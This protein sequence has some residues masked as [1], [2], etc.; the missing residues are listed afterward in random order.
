MSLRL[1]ELVNEKQLYEPLRVSRPPSLNGDSEAGNERCNAG[2][3]LHCATELRPL[4][5]LQDWVQKQGLKVAAIFEA[6]QRRSS[7]LRQVDSP[8]THRSGKRPLRH[9]D[10]RS[11][12]VSSRPAPEIQ[13]DPLTEPW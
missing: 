2:R 3:R 6:V 7:S 5:K 13:V 8:A 1:G 12:P 10:R 9:L 11:P 4:I